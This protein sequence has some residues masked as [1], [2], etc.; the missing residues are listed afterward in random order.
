ME[1]KRFLKKFET[2]SNYESQK[3][4]IMNK[5]HIVLI[6][7]TQNIIFDGM[8]FE[9][10]FPSN[11]SIPSE[12]SEPSNPSIPSEPEVDYS[13]E[14]FTIEFIEDGRFQLD[15][16]LSG[17]GSTVVEYSLNNSTWVK[18][19]PGMDGEFFTN[20]GDTV[21][22]RAISDYLGGNGDF[23]PFGN[24][25][26]KYNVKGNIMSL[27]YAED[28]EG[29][30]DLSSMKP[31]IYLFNKCVNLVNAKDLVLPAVILSEES[32]YSMFR[33]CTSLTTAPEL[34]A[35]T[36]AQRCYNSMFQGC[37]SLTTAPELPATTLATYC[38]YYM[39]NG[40]SQLNYIKMLATNISASSCLYNWVNG[41][42]SN[43]TFVKNANMTTL[44]SGTSGI[45]NGWTIE[46]A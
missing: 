27:L 34:P 13:K 20:A 46:N 29:K 40:C 30:T 5:N 4:L 44:P 8:E 14:Y 32:Y 16:S 22:L 10:T 9:P 36:L 3:D 41:V 18:L 28:F 31:F 12:P 17:S 11:P 6:N 19:T 33:D 25:E 42:A 1:K 21:Q 23:S 26:G 39:F 38:Y 7:E 35:T 45:P 15:Y 43:G 37:T 2:K 24:I